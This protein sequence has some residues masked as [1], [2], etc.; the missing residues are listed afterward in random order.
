MD[1]MQKF[2]RRLGEKSAV[3]VI[4]IIWR[5]EQGDLS[6]LDIKALVGMKGVFRCRLGDIRIIFVKSSLGHNDVI[7][8]DFRKNVYRHLKK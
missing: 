1:R 8:V 7:D 6:G 4:A 2:L 3:R 5:I